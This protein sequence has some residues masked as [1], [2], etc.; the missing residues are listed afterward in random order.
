MEHTVCHVL[1]KC[2]SC[3]SGAC[4]ED[5]TLLATNIT[6]KKTSSSKLQVISTADESRIEMGNIK[7]CMC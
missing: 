6:K 3:G 4:A 2:I 1:P 5:A 7:N